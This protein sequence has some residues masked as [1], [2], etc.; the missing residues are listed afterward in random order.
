MRRPVGGS[1]CQCRGEWRK[2]HAWE[3][4]FDRYFSDARRRDLPVEHQP[5]PRTFARR[6]ARRK[7]EGW[8]S[9]TWLNRRFFPR[10]GPFQ[11]AKR[12]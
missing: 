8:N 7:M 3:Q 4:R 6:H 2:R 5:I 9:E 11:R 10:P 1:E 12:N